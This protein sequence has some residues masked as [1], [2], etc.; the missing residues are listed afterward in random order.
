MLIVFGEAR[1]DLEEML[2]ARLD[3]FW[4]IVIQRVGASWVSLSIS[5]LKFVSRN[6]RVAS[7]QLK[8]FYNRAVKDSSC[9]N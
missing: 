5:T 6:K 8:S 9:G 4:P 3:C 7:S 2:E 1:R